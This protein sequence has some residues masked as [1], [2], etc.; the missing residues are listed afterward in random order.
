MK[1]IEEH[2]RKQLN[3][4]DAPPKIDAEDLWAGI[5]DQ[6][7]KE[8]EDKPVAVLG[9]PWMRT[10][11]TFGAALFLLLGAAGLWWKVG[12]EDDG[13]LAEQ[14]IEALTEIA[15]VTE[16][17][18]KVEANVSAS[19][20]TEP[21]LYGGTALINEAAVLPGSND[22]GTAN[23][24]EIPVQ[25]NVAVA[26]NEAKTLKGDIVFSKEETLEVAAQ[27]DEVVV[28]PAPLTLLAPATAPPNTTKNLEV[29]ALTALALIT[30]LEN[31]RLLKTV[32]ITEAKP[33]K[34]ASEPALSLGV[35]LGT[36]LL[37]R[38]YT[39][40]GDGASRK[41]NR[42]T[43]STAGQSLAFD[44]RYRISGK[45]AISSGLEYHR[46]ANTFRHVSR[47]DTMIPH[48]S[49][50]NSGMIL[51]TAQRTVAHNNQEELFTVPLLLEYQRRYGDFSLSLGVGL[52]ANFQ[53]TAS[54]RTLNA[55]GRIIDYDTANGQAITNKF[56]LS[57]QLQ[58][59]I[60]WRINPNSPFELQ[61]RT[62]LRY[63]NYG[64]SA[65][66]GTSQRGF[67]FGGGVGVRYSF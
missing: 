60:S 54:G 49:P 32:S 23:L 56:F 62:D 59:K 16:T 26:K 46:T 11:L 34:T 65:L 29:S 37:I 12:A 55:N 41:L 61:L 35:H 42:A 31:N 10:M 57:Y 52:G 7:P 44:L 6:L 63:I 50:F 21:G 27:H 43:G 48:P 47:Q 53:R 40:N 1:P 28:H 17:E 19:A 33:F 45:F 36:N 8:E 4:T 5:A 64:A 24:Q 3:R 22:A 58:P 15:V 39:S 38:R 30:S 9:Y 2:I 20:E 14:Q 13:Q 67:L 51:A 18:K 66:T 25:R